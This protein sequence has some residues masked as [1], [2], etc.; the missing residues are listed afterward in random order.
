VRSWHPLARP[1]ARSSLPLARPGGLAPRL[2]PLALPPLALLLAGCDGVQTPLDPWGPQAGRIAWLT[3]LLFGGGTAIFLLVMGL[4]GWALLAPERLRRAFGGRGFVIGGGIVFPTVTLAALLAVSLGVSRALVLPGAEAPLRIEVIGR[5]YWWE[6][7][8]PDLGAE[9][10]TANALHLPRGQEVELLLSS[11]D[12]IH[13]LWVPN[14]HG[15]MDM[16]PGRVNRQR[17]TADRTGV[18]RGQC[19]EFCGVQHSIM[20]LDVVVQEPEEFAAWARR[21]AEPVAPPEEPLLARGMA[22]FGAHGC[23]A[24]HAVRGTEWQGRLAPDL[25]RIGSRATLAAGALETHPATLAGWIAGAQDIKPGNAMPAY[26]RSIGAAD[27]LALAAWLDS[28]R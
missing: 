27:L 8:Y 6:V 16:I 22:A 7:R 3:W 4:L 24:C 21:Q 15:K 2:L 1:G 9:V 26:G 13:S 18:L 17:L 23:G 20:A 12:V 10:I 14:L 28:L 11:A 25:S 19:A 5:Q